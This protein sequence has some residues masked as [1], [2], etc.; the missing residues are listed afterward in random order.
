MT[1]SLERRKEIAALCKELKLPTIAK[2]YEYVNED[3]ADDLLTILQEERAD[4]R[5]RS[6]ARRTKEA[7]FPTL[8]TLDTFELD[9]LPNLKK[10]KIEELKTCE[11]IRQK[12]NLVAI[13]NAG[14]GKTHLLTAL[15]VEAIRQGYTVRF[16]RAADLVTQMV[17]AR[18]EK[19]LAN[20]LKGL[21]N[22]DAV[23]IDEVG[24]LNVD[25]VGASMLFQA[26]AVRYEQKSILVST[27]LE[28]SK[29]VGFLGDPPLAAALIDRLAHNSIFLNMN[30]TS[31]RYQSTMQAQ[32][33]QN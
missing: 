5:L 25:S 32:S 15:G 9:R 4:R 11:F 7:G 2:Y 20:Y 29:W 10:E 18:D 17:E 26:F 3:I 24:Y 30:G 12:Q 16:K 13:G 1:T 31:Y 14:T 22:Y 28:F 8:K 21:A 23:I 27:N 19:H 33:P 6:I